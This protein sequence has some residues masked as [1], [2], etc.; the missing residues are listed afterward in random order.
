MQKGNRSRGV[1]ALVSEWRLWATRHASF[2]LLARMDSLSTKRRAGLA[3]G[4]PPSSSASRASR[5]CAASYAN[6]VR[7]RAEALGID[8]RGFARAT[9]VDTS[10]AGST[11]VAVVAATR[12]TCGRAVEVL[13]D[14]THGHAPPLEYCLRWIEGARWASGPGSQDQKSPPAV[15]APSVVSARSADLC[16]SS[17]PL[18]TCKRYITAEQ[19]QHLEEARAS[20]P[21]GE[22]HARELPDVLQ[23]H[24]RIRE[25]ARHPSF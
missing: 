8:A 21:P 2:R 13:H 12:P 17:G 10:N 7:A 5:S 4:R 9:N 25:P 11:I 23:P 18:E 6:G 14:A 1:G 15:R 20:S 3:L 19:L 16:D 24:V 22:G